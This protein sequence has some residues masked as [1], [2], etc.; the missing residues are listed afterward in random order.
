MSEAVSPPSGP[1]RVVVVTGLSGAGKTTAL[2]VLED[3]GYEAVDNL[4][5]SLLRRLAAPDDDTTASEPRRALAVGI[6]SRTRG[7]QA[8]ALI[9]VIAELKQRSD[10]A[11]QLLYFDCNDDILLKRFTATRRRHPLAADR[12]V[13][14]GIATERRLMLPLQNEADVVLDT[15]ALAL[16]E[17]RQ[18]MATQFA[19]DALPGLSIMVTS[20]SYKHGLP[21]EADLVFDVRFLRNPHYDEILRPQTGSEPAV[22]AYVAADPGYADFFAKLT[23]MIGTLLPR[24]A[25]EGK[26]YLTIAIGC[27][28]GRHR[29][30]AVAEALG[31]HLR[32]S[33][34]RVDIRHRDRDLAP[35]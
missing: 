32:D 28:G 27:T 24:Y 22:A 15:S 10:L 20:F 21:R 26:R 1:I 14:D 13:A 34:Q 30:V 17:F 31:K 8:D 2:K 33:G 5:I 11:V 35:A 16:P 9:T 4:P 18:V 6:D 25:A 12:P 29:S 7:F 23:D 19:L 3:M